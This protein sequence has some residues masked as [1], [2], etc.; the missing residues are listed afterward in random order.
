MTAYEVL[1][2]EADCHLHNSSVA[3]RKQ[4]DFSSRGCDTS[5]AR[6]E[7]L[8]GRIATLLTIKCWTCVIMVV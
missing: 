4:I 3:V 2:R 1:E 6:A 7:T 8:L 5:L